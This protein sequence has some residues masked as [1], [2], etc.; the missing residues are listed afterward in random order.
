MATE[1]IKIKCPNLDQYRKE[2]SLDTGEVL[3]AVTK[4]GTREGEIQGVY[5]PYC[6]KEKLACGSIQMLQKPCIYLDE[7]ALRPPRALR[8]LE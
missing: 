1:Y 2:D 4:G 6:N 8:G 3:I 7:I 5:C